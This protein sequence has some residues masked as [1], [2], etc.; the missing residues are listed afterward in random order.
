ERRGA[1]TPSRGRSGAEHPAPHLCPY[2]R[3]GNNILDSVT[4]LCIVR[5]MKIEAEFPQTLMEAVQYF[6]KDENAFNFMVELRWPN[7]VCCPQCGGTKI[8]FISTRTT[9]ECK[10]CTSKKQFTVKVG[11]IFEDS[12]LP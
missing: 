11:T 3:V 7:G 2:P 12:A 1:L 4:G 9:W 6:S 8:G 10:T 5:G